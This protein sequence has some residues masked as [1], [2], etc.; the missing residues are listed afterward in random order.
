MLGQSGTKVR[1]MVPCKRLLSMALW[2]RQSLYLASESMQR[3]GNNVREVQEKGYQRFQQ[4][5][6]MLLAPSQQG[7]LTK[8]FT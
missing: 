2:K 5:G 7:I 3:R 4:E 6:I 8:C 1:S